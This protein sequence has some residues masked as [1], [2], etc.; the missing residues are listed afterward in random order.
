MG[1][2]RSPDQV[3]S[4]GQYQISWDGRDDA[5]LTL[6]AGVYYMRVR[7][8]SLSESQKMLKIQ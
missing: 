3:Q 6:G 7:V 2:Q 1:T 5:G 8:G 4:V